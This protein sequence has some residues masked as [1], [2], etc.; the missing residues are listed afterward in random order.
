MTT[1]EL[2]MRAM[3]R[4]STHALSVLSLQSRGSME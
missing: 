2:N 3:L 1:R 4:R